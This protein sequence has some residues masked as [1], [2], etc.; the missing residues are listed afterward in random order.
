MLNISK[1][2]QAPTVTENLYLKFIILSDL[3][4]VT[5]I[6]R[7]ICYN[8]KTLGLVNKKILVLVN[9]RE[10]NIELCTKLSTLYTTGS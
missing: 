2:W 6:I 4:S 8:S 10:L 1:C 7:A 5:S 9:I 3:T